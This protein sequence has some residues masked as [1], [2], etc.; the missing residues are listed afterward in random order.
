MATNFGSRTTIRFKPMGSRFRGFG[1]RYSVSGQEVKELE[2]D[3][4]DK[5]RREK[6]QGGLGVIWHLPLARQ[7]SVVIIVEA[8]DDCV[9][10]LTEECYIL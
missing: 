4:V 5:F 7:A 10:D 6:M 8:V 9:S 2:H 1:F 3:T